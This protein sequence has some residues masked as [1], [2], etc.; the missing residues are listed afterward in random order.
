MNRVR[1]VCD[2]HTFA[3]G[4]WLYFE[5]HNEVVFAI[6]VACFVL[7]IVVIPAPEQELTER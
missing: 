5:P 2:A 4:L 7:E 3:L 6:T 1:F